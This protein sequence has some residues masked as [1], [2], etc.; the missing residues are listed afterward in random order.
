MED[1]KFVKLALLALQKEGHNEI[2]GRRVDHLYN[3][4]EKGSEEGRQFIQ[5][6]VNAAMRLLRITS[7]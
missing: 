1:K 5:M 4:V 2:V 3:E 6:I 7:L